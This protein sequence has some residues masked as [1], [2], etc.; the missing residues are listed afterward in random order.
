MIYR[1]ISSGGF[2]ISVPY[3]ELFFYLKNDKI[4]AYKLPRAKSPR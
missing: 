1:L 2:D 4:R 3:R